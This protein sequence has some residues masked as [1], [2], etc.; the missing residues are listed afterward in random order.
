MLPVQIRAADPDPAAGQC[1]VMNRRGEL[2][3]KRKKNAAEGTLQASV[4]DGSGE[5][6][7]FRPFR[8]WYY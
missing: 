8:I 4:F 5:K 6:R 2:S 3:M 1:P 7:Y